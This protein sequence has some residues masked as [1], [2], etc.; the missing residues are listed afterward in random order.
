MVS[1]SSGG[2]SR[3]RGLIL[4][5]PA[6]PRRWSPHP[7]GQLVPA[8]AAVVAATRVAHRCGPDQR[9][10]GH[11]EPDLVVAEM[12]SACPNRLRLVTCAIGASDYAMMQPGAAWTGLPRRGKTC[13]RCCN[14]CRA[15]I[16]TR[17]PRSCGCRPG[18]HVRREDRARRLG[19]RDGATLQRRASAVHVLRP[20]LL[21][22][23]VTRH[24]DLEG[25]DAGVSFR[26][27]HDPQAGSTPTVISNSSD[28]GRGQSP[29]ASTRSWQPGPSPAYGV[30]PPS[31]DRVPAHRHVRA[32][33]RSPGELCVSGQGLL[34]NR[35]INFR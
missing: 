20:G 31:H 24:G 32:F 22:R 30:E 15:A 10:P 26:S 33:A 4:R 11:R 16:T 21:A 6:V 13:S 17:T 3:H 29:V 1:G 8:F 12:S 5:Q 27:V 34:S 14:Y 19:G 9:A 35:L 23:P 7:R 25:Y 2:R 18:L 28:G